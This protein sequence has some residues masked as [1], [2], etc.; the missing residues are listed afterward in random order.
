MVDADIS[1][2]RQ[3]RM[4]LVV[5]DTARMRDVARRRGRDEPRREAS[6]SNLYKR[7]RMRSFILSQKTKG[8]KGTDRRQTRREKGK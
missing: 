5:C 4:L 1:P 8:N 2:F 6:D 7:S 3:Y